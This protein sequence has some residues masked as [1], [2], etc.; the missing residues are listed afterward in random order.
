MEA[1]ED[2]VVD[3]APLRVLFLAFDAELVKV[4]L[5]FLARFSGEIT[6]VTKYRFNSFRSFKIFL[7]PIESGILSIQI[8]EFS[9]RLLTT[10]PIGKR[11][12]LVL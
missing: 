9:F 8:K 7:R 12:K 5:H 4:L 2:T 1:D 10:M 6:F 3:G 11:R